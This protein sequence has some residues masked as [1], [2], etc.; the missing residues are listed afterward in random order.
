MQ[1]RR[2]AFELAYKNDNPMPYNWTE[3]CLAGEDW[4]AGFIKR[5]K[6]ISMRTP[7]AMSLGRAASFNKSNV[8]AF[9]QNLTDVKSHYNFAPKDMWNVDETGC[10]TVQDVVQVVAPTGMKQVGST[11]GAEDRGKLVTLCCAVNAIGQA[12][13]P[14]FIFLRVHFKTHFIQAGP[15]GCI[16]TSYPTGWM[17]AETFLHFTEHFVNQV[18]LLISIVVF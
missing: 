18:T 9:F 7:E 4:F 14:M 11:A 6:D 8:A 2:L 17:T 12:L 16:G 13:P 15:T 10:N 3:N 5:H 1:V